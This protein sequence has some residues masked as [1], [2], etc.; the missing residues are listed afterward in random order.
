MHCAKTKQLFTAD[1][2]QAIYPVHIKL[3]PAYFQTIESNPSTQ[4]QWYPRG[5]QEA[6][7]LQS[8]LSK[9]L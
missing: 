9:P 3:Y 1:N 5:P 2:L 6:Q 8:F 7:P 4:T